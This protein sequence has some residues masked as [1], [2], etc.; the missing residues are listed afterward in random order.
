MSG[1]TP[2][3]AQI[4]AAI[5]LDRLR[6][7][8][9]AL[10]GAGVAVGQVEADLSAGTTANDFEADPASVGHPA[11]NT[12]GFFT[13][14]NGTLSTAT[15]NDG[16]I[17][18]ASSHASQVGSILFD[19]AQSGG[20]PIGVAPG[21]AHLD[22]YAANNFSQNMQAG[23]ADK[24]VNLSFVDGGTSNT[25]AAFDAAALSGNIVFV[26][27]AGNSGTPASPSSAYN[28]ISVDSSTNT[29]LAA[30]PAS[31]GVPKPDISAPG[32]ETSFTAPVV[33]GAAAILVQAGAAGDG[34]AGSQTKADAVD[35]RTVKALLLNSAT[36]PAD[37]YTTS[38]APSATQPLNA[39]YGAGVVNI[40][41]AVGQ[42]MGG[43]HA[44]QASYGVTTNA[45]PFRALATAPIAVSQ[46]WNLGSLT[47]A[48]RQDQVDQYGFSLTAG[49]SF[50]ATLTWASNASNAIDHL[51]LELFDDA[52]GQMLA[53]S[54][55]PASNVQQIDLS[56]VAGGRYDLDVVLAGS[57]SGSLTDIYALAFSPAAAVACFCAKTLI[58]T[59]DGARAVERLRPGDWVLTAAS[60]TH[61][62][63]VAPV[64]FVG[65]RRRDRTRAEDAPI[66]VCASAFAD[67]VPS[68]DLFLSPDHAVAVATAGGRVLVPVGL[69]ENGASIAVERDE[70]GSSAAERGE[71]STDRDRD[72]YFHVELD[73]HDVI[74]AEGL[75]VE[76]YLDT[77]NRAGFAN[78]P[79]LGVRS[80]WPVALPMP[81]APLRLRGPDVAAA[82]AALLLRAETLFAR[83][84]DPALSVR[85]GSARIVPAFGPAFVR[86]GEACFILP[87]GTARLHLVSRHFRP[88]LPDQRRLG[89]A[90]TWLM[91][92]GRTIAL[93]DPALAAGWHSRE[94][95]ARQPRENVDDAPYALGRDAPCALGRDA[96]GWRWSDGAGCLELSPLDHD[97]VLEIGWH[98]GWGSYWARTDEPAS[99]Y[100]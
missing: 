85:A 31:D 59:P 7:A 3:P 92:E 83:T 29:S 44:A 42:L 18:T 60:E 17:G 48:A 55:A 13:F 34:G 43:E 62:G 81:C 47:A 38:Y 25:D 61:P 100:A 37:Y 14:F 6:A 88:A 99:L 1:S 63:R 46:G 57:S 22:N 23:I 70:A 21:I 36:R 2:T 51:R 41:D 53:S 27:A 68:R 8:D 80:A 33:S 97:S 87:A 65:R 20:V 15:P 86:P 94:P 32:P 26:A 30:G 75:E 50:E 10:T 96:P 73:R 69:L 91:H 90:V 74:L 77:G 67:G 72:V 71:E 56:S 79:L 24:V 45:N 9:P 28:V 35:F 4:A 78:A 40:Y 89:V 93:D 39:V 76:S 16:V 12:D 49:A 58:R 5:G 52:T 98:A 66:R 11:G 54:A 82:R 84:T 19:P 95:C 64:R